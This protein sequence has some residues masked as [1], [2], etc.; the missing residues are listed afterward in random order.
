MFDAMF[1]TDMGQ[2]EELIGATYARVSTAQQKDGISLDDQADKMLSYAQQFGI[3]VPQDFR[4]RETFSGLKVERPEYEKIRELIRER[5]IR[6]LIVYSTDRH[7]RDEVHGEIFDAELRRAKCQLHV[8]TRGGQVDI[9]SAS[10]RLLNTIERAFS[11]Y[12]AQM[13]QQTTQEKKRAY[14]KD[15]IPVVQGVAPYGLERVGKKREARLEIVEEEASVVRDMFNWFYEYV[16]VSEIR[17]R[18]SSVTGKRWA[19]GTIYRMLKDEVYKGVFRAHRTE[20][21]DGV[22]LPV[23]KEQHVIIAV[24]AIVSPELWQA[25]QEKLATGRIEKAPK[26]KYQYLLSRRIKCSCGYRATAMTS[27]SHGRENRR[28][29]YY[30]CNTQHRPEW[31]TDCM[32]PTFRVDQSDAAV[33]DF[34]KALLRDERALSTALR[35]SQ[36]ELRRRNSRLY[37]RLETIEEEI[38]HN[39]KELEKLTLAFAR[40]EGVLLEMLKKQA[41]PYVKLIEGLRAEKQKLVPQL[42]AI[43]ISDDYIEAFEH[44]AKQ[45]RPRLDFVNFEEKQE[46]IDGLKLTF[47]MILEEDEKILLVHWHIYQF[48]LSLNKG[49]LGSLGS[50][51]DTQNPSNDGSGS[52]SSIRNGG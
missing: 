35:A 11:K 29:G 38:D 8:V 30:R 18:L 13:I 7:T 25:V 6:I 49:F 23:P 42:Q 45:V 28:V 19:S 26:P 44:F 27:V 22:K 16:G 33:W 31:K 48:K 32:M 5:R 9:Y 15:G 21:V 24:P 41:E 52:F 47:E 17:R 1:Q 34:T 37:E 51:A 12:W 43:S 4:F 3:S 20:M 14:L 39:S 40:T 2:T 10:G 50:I 46:I 36:H